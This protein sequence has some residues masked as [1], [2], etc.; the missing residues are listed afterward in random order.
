MSFEKD[1][2]YKIRVRVSDERIKPGSTMSK[3]SIET[4]PK[5]RCH[6]EPSAFVASLGALFV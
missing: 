3:W 4:S 5:R 6:C 2:W 1:R